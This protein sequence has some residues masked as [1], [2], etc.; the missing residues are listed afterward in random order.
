MFTY[1]LLQNCISTSE[2][3][4][5]LRALCETFGDIQELKVI[6]APACVTPRRSCMRPTAEASVLRGKRR[7]MCFLRMASGQQ[8]EALLSHIGKDAR[9][10]RF[11]GDVVLVIELKDP[12]HI[13]HH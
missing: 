6:N 3:E 2:V 7:A 1:E 12:P 10:G 4:T 8:E 13:V 9:K 11:G 5:E